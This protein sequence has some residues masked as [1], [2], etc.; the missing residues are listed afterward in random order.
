[1]KIVKINFNHC[2]KAQDLLQQMVFKGKATFAIIS[3]QYR[4]NNND[5]FVSD[6]IGKPAVWVCGNSAVQDAMQFLGN[7]FI[8]VKVHSVYFYSCYAPPKPF[9]L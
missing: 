3:E 5:T 6:T 9:S 1:M 2:E 8:W 4:Q 7:G